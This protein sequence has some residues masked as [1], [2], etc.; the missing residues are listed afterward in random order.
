[1]M[2]LFA[3]GKYG[4]YIWSSFA[5]MIF[6]VVACTVQARKRHR[7]VYRRIERDLKS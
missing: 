2:E 7:D 6:V 1:M 5:L 4:P 3:M